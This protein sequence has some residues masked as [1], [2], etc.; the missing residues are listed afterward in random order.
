MGREG[1][2]PA[3]CVLN[4]GRFIVKEKGLAPVFLDSRLEHPAGWI[5]ARYKSSVLLLLIHYSGECWGYGDPHY[6]DFNGGEFDHQ[7]QCTYILAQDTSDP[8]LFTVLLHNVECE[9][10]PGTTCPREVEVL[11]DG[12][13]VRMLAER[14]DFGVSGLMRQLFLD[15][16]TNKCVAL[17]IFIGFNGNS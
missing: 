15:L 6:F 8:P 14:N 11:Y 17:C 2:G 12:H 3:C 10:F 5:C 9:W 7:G 1:V 16:M 4:P 13:K